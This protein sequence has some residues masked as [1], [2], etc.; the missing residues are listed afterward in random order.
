MWKDTGKQLS[1]LSWSASSLH[2]GSLKAI[3]EDIY[4]GEMKTFDFLDSVSPTWK[5]VLE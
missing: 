2:L 1:Q 5:Q 3:A 4:L